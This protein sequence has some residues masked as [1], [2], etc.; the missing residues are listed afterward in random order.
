M[1]ADFCR[2]LKEKKLTY[3]TVT[4]RVIKELREVSKEEKYDT[5]IAEQLKAMEAALEKEKE[6]DLQKH[7]EEVCEMLK[8]E[9][10][11]RYYYD[12]GRIQGALKGDKVLL[13]A[14]D[15]MNK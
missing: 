11:N 1:Y 7:R 15:E 5:A 10:L 4:E 6:G 3:S 9:L 13:R 14:I 12:E 8:A 2:Y